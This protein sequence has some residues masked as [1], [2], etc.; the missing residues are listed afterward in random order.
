[1]DAFTPSIYTDVRNIMA[2]FY[3]NWDLSTIKIT[4]VDGKIVGMGWVSIF[5]G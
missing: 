2:K 3:R 5:L 4:E 1:M